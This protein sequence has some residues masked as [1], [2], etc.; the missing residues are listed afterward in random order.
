MTQEQ[1]S[2]IARI[3]NDDLR[4]DRYSENKDEVVAIWQDE[5]LHRP[6]FDE[7]DELRHKVV[8]WGCEFEIEYEDKYGGYVITVVKNH[9]S[10]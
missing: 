8:S 1:I 9:K 3:L 4:C 5:T 2:T 6:S 7:L 10:E